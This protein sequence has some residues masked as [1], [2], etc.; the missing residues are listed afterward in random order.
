MVQ[1]DAATKAGRGVDV[2]SQHLGG[3]TSEEGGEERLVKLSGCRCMHAPRR[4]FIHGCVTTHIKH[5]RRSQQQPGQTKDMGDPCSSLFCPPTSLIRVCRATA[6]TFWP[7]IHMNPDAAQTPLLTHSSPTPLTHLTHSALQGHGHDLLALT[8]P[9]GPLLLLSLYYSCSH[10]TTPSIS[11]SITH[12]PRIHARTHS[13]THSPTPLTH[14]T[15]S[16]LQCHSHDL[17]PPHPQSMC[18]AV[19]LDSMVALV[20]Q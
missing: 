16:A 8:A 7:R 5:T 19:R 11:H 14:L 18:N 13:H 10:S 6:M 17:L 9:T 15:H 20:V 12:P 1:Q 4:L 3:G 2:N